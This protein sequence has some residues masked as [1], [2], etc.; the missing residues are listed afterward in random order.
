MKPE[1]QR[2]PRL[3]RK[4]NGA[5]YSRAMRQLQKVYHTQMGIARGQEIEKGTEEIFETTMTENFI[6]LT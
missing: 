5:E 1:K 4:K 3:K 6:K 2:E